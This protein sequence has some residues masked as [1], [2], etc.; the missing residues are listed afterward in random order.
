[1]LNPYNE[2]RRAAAVWSHRNVSSARRAVAERCSGGGGG[3]GDPA[4]ALGDRSALRCSHFQPSKDGGQHH[5]RLL[6]GVM[7]GPGNRARRDAIRQTWMSWPS[8]GRTVVVCFAIGRRQVPVVTLSR[9]DAEAAEHGD[10]LFLPVADG[11]VKQVSIGKMHAFWLAAARRLRGVPA[12]AAPL[13]VKAD[14]D[15]V[16]NLPLLQRTLAPLRCVPRLYYGAIAFTG[17]QPKGFMNCGFAWSG[18]GA[19]AKYGCARSGAHPPFPFA[20]GQLQVL[21]ASLVASLAASQDAAEFAAAAEGALDTLANE[22]SALG[23][24]ISML[25]GVA[26]VGMAKRSWHN[27]GCIQENGMYR[28]PHNGSIVVH[29]VQTAAGLRYVSRVLRGHEPIDVVTCQGALPPAWPGAVFHA[30]RFCAHCASSQYKRYPRD[31][32]DIS[33]AKQHAAVR[34]SCARN[35]LLNASTTRLR[36]DA[37]RMTGRSV[38]R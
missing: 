23:F 4:S 31:C 6:V 15:S 16:V 14:D 25:P 22:D 26:Y 17:Y 30:A 35:G 1:M 5:V 7:T 28:A 13:V 19:Y 37:M 3:S 24:M 36:N 12:A 2:S 8:V 34:L 10:L 32:R 9:L 29:R 21:S 11:C 20:L 18:G 27:L 33:N 38:A